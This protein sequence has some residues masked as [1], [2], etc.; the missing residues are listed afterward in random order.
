MTTVLYADVLFIINFS[1]DFLSLYIT[2]KLLSLRQS[3]IRF[4][5]AA[6]IG[7]LA[8]T[9]MT[10]LGIASLPEAVLSVLISF[11]MTAVATGFLGLR[12]FFVRAFAL[13]GAGALLGGAVSVICSLGEAPVF[14]EERDEPSSP[15]VLSMAVGTLLVILFIR[16]IRPKLRQKTTEL[17][18]TFGGNSVTVSALV[19]SG[20]LAADPIS[21]APVIFL[22]SAEAISLVGEENTRALLT[23]DRDSLSDSMTTRL[24]LVPVSGEGADKLYFAFRPD[25]VTVGKKKSRRD[26]LIAISDK[27]RDFYAGHPA[28]APSCVL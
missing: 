1:M 16:L 6:A 8:A 12:S 25:S 24:R 4:S 19:D 3:A 13:W 2:A 11:A 14:R 18:V 9:V 22:S 23:H 27:G 26:V 15:Y 5:I 21:G 20:N 7:A 28:L 10:A 17:T